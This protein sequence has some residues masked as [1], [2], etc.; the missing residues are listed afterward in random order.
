M[1]F[2]TILIMVVTASST[3]HPRFCINCK[4]FI[5]PESGDLYAKCGAFP[6]DDMNYLIYG[7]QKEYKYCTTARTFTTLCGPNATEY[8]ENDEYNEKEEC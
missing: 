4:H 2:I 5:A 1:W 7:V 6:L 3:I 8:E